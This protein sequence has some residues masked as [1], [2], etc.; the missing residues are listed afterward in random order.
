VGRVTLQTIADE[1]GVSRTTVSNAFSRPDQLSAELRDRIHDA[2]QRLGYAGPDPLARG[3]RAGRVGAIGVLM[4]EPLAYALADPYT[5]DL[6]VG[7]GDGVVG[8]EHTGLLLIPLPPGQEPGPVIQRAVVDGFVAF[9]LPDDHP[10]IAAVTARGLPLVTID[11]PRL[12]SVPFV[13]IEERRAAREL[14]EH[15]LA[16]GHRRLLVLT[17][18]VVDDEHT[19]PVD[20][21]RLSRATYHVTRERLAGIL[22]ATSAAG[23]DDAEVAI[24]EVGAQ[25]IDLAQ[26]AVLEQLGGP[27]APTAIM[28]LSDRLALGALDALTGRGVDVPG[29]VSVTGFDDLAPAAAAGLTTVHQPAIDKGRLAA[30]LLAGVA[31]SPPDPLPYRLVVRSSVGPPPA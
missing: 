17:F 9:I 30:Q 2:A 20:A 23:L 28:A 27:D 1:L 8:A 15:V 31:A 16:Q 25:R 11:G 21:Q 29:A 22:D 13:T 10:S 12:P 3:L 6:L 18:R 5:A 7:L 14:A 26:Q 24:Q 4:T 19:G